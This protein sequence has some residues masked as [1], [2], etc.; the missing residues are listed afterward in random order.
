MQP[1]GCQLAEAQAGLKETACAAAGKAVTTGKAAAGAGGGAV[2]AL[3]PQHS[4]TCC[5]A[6]TASTAWQG[7]YSLSC[8]QGSVM[9]EVAPVPVGAA[10]MD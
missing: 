8:L 5:T 7:L 6:C 3:G 1:W 9:D 2:T 4:S 10:A